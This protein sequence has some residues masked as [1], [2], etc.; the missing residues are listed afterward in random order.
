MQPL[1]ISAAVR[2]KKGGRLGSVRRNA[3]GRDAVFLWYIDCGTLF[4]W[5]LLC[6]TDSCDEDQPIHHND[7]SRSPD[8]WIRCMRQRGL[9]GSRHGRL[10]TRK[11]LVT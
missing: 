3:S 10:P 9:E 4:G 1:R 2:A 5:L 7:Y 6:P 11:D 8:P